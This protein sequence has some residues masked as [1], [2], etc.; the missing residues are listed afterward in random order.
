MI[1]CADDASVRHKRDGISAHTD[2]HWSLRIAS[3]RNASLRDAG[4]S[5]LLSR[6]ERDTV[7]D[8]SVFFDIKCFLDTDQTVAVCIELGEDLWCPGEFTWREDT[9]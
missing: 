6:S 7:F 4:V 2:G 1:R 3:L 5:A 8:S 9:V